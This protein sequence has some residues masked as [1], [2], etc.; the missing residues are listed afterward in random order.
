MRQP[1][2]EHFISTIF[3]ALVHTWEQC[4]LGGWKLCAPAAEYCP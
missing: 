1:V 2:Y 4:M 3:T